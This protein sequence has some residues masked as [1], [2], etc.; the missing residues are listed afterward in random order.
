MTDN[1]ASLKG[2]FDRIAEL[3]AQATPHLQAV[4]QSFFDDIIAQITERAGSDAEK[5]TITRTETSVNITYPYYSGHY[6][7]FVNAAVE[8]HSDG[9]AYMKG[10][11]SQNAKCIIPEGDRIM[12]ANI[13]TS[14]GYATGVYCGV[15]HVDRLLKQFSP[16]R[17]QQVREFDS[18]PVEP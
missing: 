11:H 3:M 16:A 10:Y 6:K 5:L 13:Y 18:A 9:Y 15:E 12:N 14:A 17:R 2:D 8:I 7:G 1:R 4:R